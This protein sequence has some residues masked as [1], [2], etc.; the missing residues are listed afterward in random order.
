M[1]KLNFS[2]AEE[3]IFFDTE[4]QNLLPP[5][6]FSIFEQWR[7]AKRISYLAP[8]GKQAVLDFLNMLTDDDLVIMGSE[9][10]VLPIPESK[11]VQKWRLQPG[12][13]FMIDM[14]QGRI[15]DDVELKNA[16]S[17]AKPYKSWIDAVRVKLDEVEVGKADLID[18]KTTIQ[19]G[20][21]H[22]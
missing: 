3:L 4:V 14:E 15:I 17:K 9:A 5:T 20:R 2:N 10:G 8:M 16:V 12:K 6:M 22:V 18:E 1:L 21:A 19:I 7:L 11:V 13:M